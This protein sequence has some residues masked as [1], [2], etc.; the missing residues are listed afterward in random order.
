MLYSVRIFTL[1]PGSCMGR[2]RRD[3]CG[4]EKRSNEFLRWDEE[5]VIAQ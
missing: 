5:Q 1:E 2:V 4:R 3:I